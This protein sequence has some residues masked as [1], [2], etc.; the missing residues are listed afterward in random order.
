MEVRLSIQRDKSDVKLEIKEGCLKRAC[1]MEVR[2]KSIIPDNEC[3]ISPIVEV[4]APAET[5]TSLC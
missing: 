5:S 1:L 2:T 3:F 4:V